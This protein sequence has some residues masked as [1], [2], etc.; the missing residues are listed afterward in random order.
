MTIRNVYLDCEFLPADPSLR[1][2]V[3]I[4][5]TDDRGVEYYAVNRD[6]DMKAFKRSEWMMA[7]VWPSLPQPHGDS[8]LHGKYPRLRVGDPSVKADGRIA[9]DIADYFAATDA[10]TTHLWAWYG[11]QDM[12]RLHSLWD[13]DWALM[14]SQIP[15]WFNELETLRWQAGNPEMPV[16][17]AGLHNA[18]AD[19]KHNRTMHEFLLEALAANRA[20]DGGSA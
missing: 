6:F 9:A 8:R 1:G 2:L 13:N 5:L 10:T 20:I 18:L 4:G 14:P 19:A 15:Q 11:A 3:S 7:N 16:Q 12:C 17:P